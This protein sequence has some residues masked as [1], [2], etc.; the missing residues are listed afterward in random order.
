MRLTKTIIR[1]FFSFGP[2]E[3]VIP[4][5]DIR[6]ALFEGENEAS[7][8]SISNGAGKT[9]VLEAVGWC[10][11]GKTSKEVAADDVVNRYCKKAGC[12]VQNHLFDPLSGKKWIITRYRK[13]PKFDNLLTFVRIDPDGAEHD[14]SGVDAP[15]TQENIIKFLGQSFKLFCNTSYFTQKNVKPFSLFTDKQIKDSLMECL[16]TTR[17]FEARELARADLKIVRH[18]FDKVTGKS[19][20]VEEEITETN[21]RI[22]R[23]TVDEANFATKKK[24]ELAEMKKSLD[25]KKSE[26]VRMMELTVTRNELLRKI[27]E[28]HE[29]VTKRDSL[30]SEKAKAEKTAKPFNEKMTVLEAKQSEISR[31]YSAKNNEIKRIRERVGTNC[32]ECGKPI[33]EED[34]AAVLR[35]SSEMA[36]ILRQ[37]SENMTSL[38]E[39]VKTAGNEQNVY[40]D[41][42]DGQIETCNAVMEEITEMNHQVD[43]LGRDLERLPGVEGEIV[44]IENAIIRKKSETSPFAKLLR[45]EK[46]NAE[47]LVKRQA[48]LTE[49]LESKKA[50][51]DKL[52]YLEFMFG[53][54]GIPGFLLDQVA[55]FLN[56]RSNYYAAMVCE[57]EITITFSTTTLSKKGELKE[58]FSITVENSTG[59][60]NYKGDSGGEQKRADI[61]IAQAMQDLARNYGKNPIDVVFYDEPFGNLDS[62]GVNGVVE[63]LEAV[64]KEVGTT[65]V[66]THDEELKSMFEQRYVIQKNAADGYSR[67]VA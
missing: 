24:A 46:K 32:S 10:N 42:L 23:Y 15:S 27:S 36:E 16:D 26:K 43:I 34:V 11:Y 59:A 47:D 4:W 37:K 66:I 63:M 48:A 14:L 44:E 58:K 61:C 62:A 40:I 51:I 5:D 64:S 13:D 33:T 30:I 41:D 20:R 25:T 38:L 22:E 6:L 9:S 53:Y 55:P 45:E 2:E 28:K 67:L 54:S 18:E 7:K 29:A 50:K 17:F 56:E 3:E 39:R 12:M 52:E 57:G 49:L 21:D 65:V 60:D 1:G 35:A 19:Q 31:Q 8:T